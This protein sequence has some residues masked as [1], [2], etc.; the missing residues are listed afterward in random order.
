[1]IATSNNFVYFK[2]YVGCHNQKQYNLNVTDGK[3]EEEIS[4]II[5]LGDLNQTT[6]H[7]KI[8]ED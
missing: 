7:L 3:S 2:T 4:F 8:A 5:Q 6:T 1:M